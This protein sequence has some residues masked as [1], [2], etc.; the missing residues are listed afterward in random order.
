MKTTASHATHRPAVRTS[1]PN[2]PHRSVV[3]F[4]L[5]RAR[6]RR[7][8]LIAAA[9]ARRRRVTNALMTGIVIAGFITAGYTLHQ[10][11]Q[12]RQQHQQLERAGW[13]Q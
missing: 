8:A 4:V 13:R 3:S 1:N 2:D 7:A 9:D 11:E 5:Y 6:K 10:D 12:I